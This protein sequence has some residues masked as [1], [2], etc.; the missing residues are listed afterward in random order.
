MMS[1]E[2]ISRDLLQGISRTCE[3]VGEHLTSET[4]VAIL[5]EYLSSKMT[6]GSGKTL[7]A[8]ALHADALRVVY[9][10]IFADGN[11]S[12]DEL[13]G[14]MEFLSAMAVVFAKVRSDY[15][16][17]DKPSRS[18]IAKF[19]DQYRR[20]K[21]TFGYCDDGTKW[22][23][24][25]VCTNIEAITGDDFIPAG[26][27]NV[28]MQAAAALSG[29]DGVSAKESEF[30]ERLAAELGV[31]SDGDQD[32]SDEEDDELWGGED[33][34][35]DELE[36]DDDDLSSED[37]GEEAD[38]GDT[39]AD[40]DGA[41]D[42]EAGSGRH[43]M[44]VS[45]TG[46]L[47]L[48]SDTLVIEYSQ[49]GWFE[50]AACGINFM[51][52]QP[53][54]SGI[55]S[56]D[57]EISED[58]F[59]RALRLC[60]HQLAELLASKESLELPSIDHSALLPSDTMTWEQV[61]SEAG[62]PVGGDSINRKEWRAAVVENRAVSLCYTD[63]EE[64]IGVVGPFPE[65]YLRLVFPRAMPRWDVRIVEIDESA[66]ETIQEHDDEAVNTERRMQGS[67][68][69][70]LLKAVNEQ[71]VDALQLAVEDGADVDHAYP[72]EGLRTALHLAALSGSLSLVQWLILLGA[73]LEG[74]D[75]QGNSAWVLAKVADNTAVVE[76]LESRGAEKDL[77]AAL[78][79]AT[80]LGK[81]KIIKRLRDEGA[82]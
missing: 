43:Y 3:L 25:G 50:G 16:T 10:A 12:D 54:D 56:S 44:E 45:P 64:L 36:E 62:S 34:D 49:S 1:I 31:H 51:A 14:S 19:L 74:R 32:E 57:N 58:I 81:N 22:S 69:E 8:L 77:L 9:D 78:R 65:P 60:Q 7:I 28:L 23:G 66:I 27:R 26:F 17:P 46:R 18:A 20:D 30:L 5:G 38:D 37:E 63:D 52:R 13:D 29:L 76:F 33:Q 73:D 80:A 59:K 70:R 79:H 41:D 55:A 71:D 40:D 47:K 75:G 61:V 21:G 35:E 67:P 39:D 53:E 82:L 11:A 4:R 72:E 6:R 42:S 48:Q 2:R 15:S 68:T 24:L